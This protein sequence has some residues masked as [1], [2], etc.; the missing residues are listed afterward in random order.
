MTTCD[1]IFFFFNGANWT[2]PTRQYWLAPIKVIQAGT[3][4]DICLTAFDCST[5]VSETLVKLIKEGLKYIGEGACVVKDPHR[6]E[7]V[8][9]CQEKSAEEIG[10]ENVLETEQHCSNWVDKVRSKNLTNTLVV[11]EAQI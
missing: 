1:S 11:K 2:L 8:L 6:P 3:L 10:T 9:G 4:P 5:V 7:Y